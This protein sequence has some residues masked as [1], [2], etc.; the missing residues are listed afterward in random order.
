MSV[1]LEGANVAWQSG[2]NI[3]KVLATQT[4]LIIAV[5]QTFSDG[6]KAAESTC[7]MEGLAERM[8][9]IS[10]PYPC[11][12]CESGMEQTLARVYLRTFSYILV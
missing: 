6:T 4:L 7:H 2:N 9:T 1:L 3:F 10:Q 11:S 12:L 8:Y 5:P